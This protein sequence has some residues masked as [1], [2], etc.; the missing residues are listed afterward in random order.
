MKLLLCYI[1]LFLP[2]AA[3][4]I[5]FN[6]NVGIKAL[7]V[8]AFYAGTVAIALEVYFRGLIQKELRGKFNVLVALIIAAII[9]AGCNMY[10]FNRVTSYKQIILI[11]VFSFCVAGITGIVIES[12]GNIIFT[13]LFNVIYL[14]LTINF[15]GGGKKLLLSQGICMAILFVYGVYLL[16]LYF[17]N[18]EVE[19][20]EEPEEQKDEESDFDEEGNITL[21]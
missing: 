19:K 20:I 21:E 18:N 2:L 17:K 11:C 12:K 4:F 1:P 3:L 5:A 6:K 10:Y 8:Q 7:I 14:L 16:V 13:F 15:K 9:Y